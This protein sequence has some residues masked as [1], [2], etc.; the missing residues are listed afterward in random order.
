MAAD[1]H[2]WSRRRFLGAG[3]AVSAGL[4]VGACSLNR[5]S[6]PD[7]S[8]QA[9]PTGWAGEELAPPWAKPDVTFTDLDGNPFPFV[10]K[11]AGKLTLLFF[12]YTNCPDICPVYLNTLASARAAIGTGPGSKPDVYFVGVDL[13]R[14]TPDVVKTY[15]A[16]ID[17]TFRGLT[18]SEA[19]VAEALGAVY[20]PPVELGEPD[21]DGSY[22]V[23]HPAWV[24]VYQAEDD[25]AHR[26]YPYG[27]RQQ[28]WVK[29]LPR[30]A[31]GEFA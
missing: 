24:T 21:A 8:A 29:D 12:G 10:E 18:G 3:A 17:P 28:E 23:G 31:A 13:A 22:E 11:T 16:N 5:G 7:D 15:L 2:P 30:L 20:A 1:P 26:R 25:K 27:V 9:K 14:D 4:A 19:V 6:T